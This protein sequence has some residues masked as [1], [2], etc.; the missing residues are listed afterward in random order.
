MWDGH[1]AANLS[2]VIATNNSKFYCNKDVDPDILDLI[3]LLPYHEKSHSGTVFD[4]WFKAIN[5]RIRFWGKGKSKSIFLW[6]VHGL[7]WRL[8]CRVEVAQLLRNHVWQL[9]KKI[10]GDVAGHPGQGLLDL[11]P[12]GPIEVGE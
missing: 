11:V 6:E 8:P 3:E 10:H 12:K 5:R 7:A 2:S 9:C 1:P 4:H